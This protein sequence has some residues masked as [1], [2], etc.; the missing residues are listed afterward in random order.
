MKKTNLGISILL[1]C[2]V[3]F[4]TP[5]TAFAASP[6]KL[7]SDVEADA[8]Y[9]ESIEYCVENGLMSGTAADTFSPDVPMSRAMLATVLY[10]VAGNPDVT[11]LANFS[12]VAP[13]TWYTDAII[14]SAQNGIMAG[15]GS[16]LFGT[17][18]PVTR[19]QIAT[20][21]WRYSGSDISVEN[22]AG[23]FADTAEISA[24]AVEAVQWAK[25]LGIVNGKTGNLFDPKSNATRAEVAT[26][27]HNYFRNRQPAATEPEPEINESDKP[28][29]D[30]MNISIAVGNSTFKIKLYDND[31]AKA[32]LAQLPLTLDMSELNGNEKYFFMPNGLPTAS[33]QV[34][35]IRAGDLMLYGSDCLVLFYESFSTSYNYTKIGYIEDVSGLTNAL[36]SGNVTVTFNAD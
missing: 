31:T 28:E 6:D 15:Y 25:N 29:G 32:L 20:T 11:G 36:G 22:R 10:R 35:N 16:G 19:E 8:W 24:F 13:D 1:I 23:G 5:A 21:L 2:T 34:G 18:D 12:D 26:I 27:L 9:L 4:F 33:E 7:F 14:W 17:N 30:F 3:L